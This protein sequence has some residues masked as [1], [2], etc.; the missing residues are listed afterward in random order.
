MSSKTTFA[1]K[2]RIKEEAGFKCAIPNCNTTSPLDLHHIIHSEDGGDESDDNLICL[3][4]NCHGRYH[5]GLIPR[6]SIQ[7][8][9]LR[10]KR[11]SADLFQHEYN[12]LEKLFIGQ[13]IELD[14]EGVNLARRLERHGLIKIKNKKD[15]L[16]RLI[17]T[18]NGADFIS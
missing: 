16:F 2:R 18:T 9:K 15:G 4:R 5:E 10:L 6:I 11:I 12:F 1:Q 13:I 7:N 14:S 17:I 8:Y 3:C